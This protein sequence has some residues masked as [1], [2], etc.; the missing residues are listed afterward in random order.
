M[1]ALSVIILASCTDNGKPQTETVENPFLTEYQTPFKVV[2]FD[3]IKTEHY[4]PAFEAG[5]KEQLAEI[6]AIVNNTEEPTFQNTILPYDKSG[7]TLNW[8][9]FCFDRKQWK[10]VNSSISILINWIVPAP[11]L[12]PVRMVQV[13]LRSWQKR[14]LWLL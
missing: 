7:E 11:C 6:D 4:M 9:P 8:R 12:L 2:P 13:W 10:C 5:M 3:K 1:I 14:E